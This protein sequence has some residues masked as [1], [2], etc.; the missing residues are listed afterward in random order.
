M[1]SLLDKFRQFFPCST[2]S[3]CDPYKIASEAL[4]FPDEIPTN[5]ISEISFF[6]PAWGGPQDGTQNAK[7]KHLELLKELAK[8][9]GV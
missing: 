2:N 6:D 9:L 4:E 8:R 3:A 1:Q 7:K 5:S